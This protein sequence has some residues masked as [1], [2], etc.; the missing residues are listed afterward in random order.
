MPSLRP[1]PKT[2]SDLKASILRPSLT[3]TFQCWFNPPVDVQAYAVGLGDWYDGDLI[4]LSCSDTVLPGS[5][6]AT[7]DITNDFSGVTERHADRR[8]FDERIDFSFYVDHDYTIIRFFEDWMSYIVNDDKGRGN[9][10]NPSVYDRNYYY[11]VNFPD[12]NS[13]G[14]YKTTVYLRKFEKDYVGTQLEYS[15]INAYP[16]NISSMPVSYNDSS[17]LKCT[18][19]FT[20]SRY[21]T[22]NTAGNNSIPG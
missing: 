15:F 14:G 7:H 16:L 9:S 19:G 11:R 8:I 3:S 17:V 12:G 18:V 4:S 6:L 5:S 10:A 1:Q 22:R 21:I 13:S 20:Y 2:L